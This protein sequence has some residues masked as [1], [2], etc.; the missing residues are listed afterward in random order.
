MSKGKEINI[1]NVAKQQEGNVLLFDLHGEVLRMK[2]PD[3]PGDFSVRLSG[4]TKTGVSIDGPIEVITRQEVMQPPVPILYDTYRKPLLYKSNANTTSKS[5]ETSILD[6][7]TKIDEQAPKKEAVV[8]HQIPKTDSPQELEE[9]AD[10]VI[11]PKEESDRANK[12]AM[13][14]SAQEKAGKTTKTEKTIKT[15][16]DYLYDHADKNPTKVPAKTSNQPKNETIFEN[17]LRIG[18]SIELTDQEL[19]ERIAKKPMEP[20]LRMMKD[21]RMKKAAENARKQQPGIEAVPTEQKSTE[22]AAPASENSAKAKVVTV[23]ELMQEY[24]GLEKRAQEIL[25]QI[26]QAEQAQAKPL[27]P[28][29]NLENAAQAEK[30]KTKEKAE[31]TKEAEPENKEK[32]LQELIAEAVNEKITAIT[33]EKD[34]KIKELEGKLGALNSE[35]ETRKK[36]EKEQKEFE[37]KLKEKRSLWKKIKIMFHPKKDDLVE[38]TLQKKYLGTLV[39]TAV[40]LGLGVLSGFGIIS[41]AQQL[42][43]I[44]YVINNPSTLFLN[45]DKIL[46]KP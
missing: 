28:N 41:V 20:V 32:T 44:P 16:Y 39:S 24:K 9:K 15:Y 33:A 6:N 31:A 2:K 17:A 45:S 21:A 19:D 34:E 27:T 29:E 8:V 35:F 46:L 30:S 13:E 36:A 23:D 37:T 1:G 7:S 25:Q 14:R 43:W 5:K 38:K 4:K 22:P 40:G 3:Q 26:A 11:K 12:L 42:G 18:K 10:E